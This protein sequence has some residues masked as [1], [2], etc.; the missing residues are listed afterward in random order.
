M[1]VAA[2]GDVGML[3]KGL[4]QDSTS[5]NGSSA[6]SLRD[7]PEHHNNRSQLQRTPSQTGKNHHG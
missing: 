1:L 6:G 5:L 3:R 2:V 7:I 4:A